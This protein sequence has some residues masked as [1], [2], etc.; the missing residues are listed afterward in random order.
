MSGEQI[1]SEWHTRGGG[2]VSLEHEG[3][4]LFVQ[5][6]RIQGTTVDGGR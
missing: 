4:D 5:L 3:G 2:I 6:L 1:D